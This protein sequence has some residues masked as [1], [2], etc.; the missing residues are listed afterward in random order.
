MRP[1]CAQQAAHHMLDVGRPDLRGLTCKFVL[2]ESGMCRL[3]AY[4]EIA[5][6][7]TPFHC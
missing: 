4:Y 7:A 2:L 1:L 6:A 3:P 5:A